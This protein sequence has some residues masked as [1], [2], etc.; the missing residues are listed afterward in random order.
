MEDR[1][2]YCGLRPSFD[3]LIRAQAK[4]QS[5]RVGTLLL[6]LCPDVPLLRRFVIL[7]SNRHRFTRD[8]GRYWPLLFV[9]V[10]DVFDVFVDVFEDGAGAGA[11]AEPAEDDEAGGFSIV[12]FRLLYFAS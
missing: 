10:F 4:K 3:R 5:A 8:V 1:W 7:E 2:R 11:G 9:D 12:L 6:C